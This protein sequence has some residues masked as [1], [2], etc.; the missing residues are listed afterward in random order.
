M[1]TASDSLHT[2]PSESVIKKDRLIFPSILHCGAFLSWLMVP[3]FASAPLSHQQD[4]WPYLAGAGLGPWRVFG[5][6]G[7]LRES[8]TS[9][10]LDLDNVPT[11]GKQ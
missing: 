10:P 5:R 3:L 1:S 7:I 8:P 11:D 6:V 2:P 9:N 4:K